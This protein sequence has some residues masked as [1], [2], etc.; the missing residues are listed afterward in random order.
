MVALHTTYWLLYMILYWVTFCNIKILLSWMKF[1][2]TYWGILKVKWWRRSLYIFIVISRVKL[3]IGYQPYQGEMWSGSR[4][5]SYIFPDCVTQLIQKHEYVT[6]TVGCLTVHSY[7]YEKLKT[8]NLT[9]T[10]SGSSGTVFVTQ[11]VTVVKS[12]AVE[13]Q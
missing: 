9:T 8:G 2:F 7:I 4:F 10:V 3:C 6:I 1:P 11:Y 12:G 5:L 13:H